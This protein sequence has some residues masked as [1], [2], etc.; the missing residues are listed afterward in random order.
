MKLWQQKS[1]GKSAQHKGGAEIEQFLSGNDAILDIKLAQYDCLASIA[2]AEALADAE[3]ISQKECSALKKELVEIMKLCK[4]GKFNISPAEEDMHTKIEEILTEKLGKT[5]KKIHACRSR[6]D[7]ALTT[8]RLY[9]KCELAGIKNRADKLA[10]AF[11]AFSA[12]NAG[13]PMPGY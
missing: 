2:H 5:G 8:L 4:K 13:K 9:M 12:A 11:S 3:V 7:Q 10:A 1:K 6:N